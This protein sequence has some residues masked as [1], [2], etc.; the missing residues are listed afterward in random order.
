MPSVPFKTLK[1]ISSMRKLALG[2][3]DSPKDPSVNVQLD[4]DITLLIHR[5]SGMPKITLKHAFLK[6]FSQLLHDVPELNTVLIRNKFRQRK[7]NRI[8]IP[9]LFRHKKIVDLNGVSM[10]DAFKM[11]MQELKDNWD[12]KISDLR[13]GKNKQNKR[14]VLIFKYLPSRFSR[15]LIKIIDF[16]AYT[17]NISL[18]WFGLPSDPFGS[19]TITYLDKYDIRYAKIPIFPFSRSPI[20]LAIGKTYCENEK[21]FAPISCTFDHRYFDGHETNKAYKKLKYY[22]NNPEKVIGSFK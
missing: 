11:T 13:S 20:T 1:N 3:W 7:N 15:L 18:N 9:T 17:N 8:F 19:M 12:Q 21:T 16:I 2:A 22:L 6:V 5:L 14:A 4:L 10:D